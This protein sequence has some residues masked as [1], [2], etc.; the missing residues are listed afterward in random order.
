M[1][2]FDFELRP[3]L[4]V[5]ILVITIIV[6]V[7]YL[8]MQRA[9]DQARNATNWVEHSGEV[10]LAAISLMYAMRDL[11]AIVVGE[12]SHEPVSTGKTLYPQRRADAIQ[13]L[14]VLREWTADNLSQQ[15]RVGSLKTLVD[16][17]LAEFD[18]MVTA[19]NRGEE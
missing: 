1:K 16:G 7:P 18:T 17:R 14:T 8:F 2:S 6:S 13:A 4:I 5:L 15:N 19:L 10:K 3:R 11:E 9:G 12:L